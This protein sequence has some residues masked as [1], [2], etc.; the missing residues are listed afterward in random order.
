[1]TDAA[2]AV[3]V[4]MPTF[5][6]APFLGE[7]IGSVLAQ[8][9]A[10][11]ELIVVDDGSTDATDS[12]LASFDD[13]RLRV[14]RRHH[15]GVRAALKAGLQL[16]RGCY[17]ARNDSDDVW[18]PEL[19]TQLLP[20]LEADARVGAVYGRATHID[21]SGRPM[22]GGRG[23][24]LRRPADPLGSLLRTDY[25]CA[26]T[27]VVRREAVD[28]S[29]WADGLST[30]E[31]WETVLRVA[32][33]Y[34]VRFV[35]RVVAQVRLHAGNTIAGPGHAARALHDRLA[36]LESVLSDPAMP[37]ALAASAP[38][39]RREVYIGTALQYVDLRAYGAALRTLAA[40]LAAGGN[41]ARSAARIAWCML[42]WMV[43]S[44]HAFSRTLA[45]RALGYLR[46]S[47]PGTPA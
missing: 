34:D 6:R 10:D 47:A 32:L 36:V 19:L 22:P 8:R 44:R 43:I 29:G 2:P 30:S 20:V 31:D 45:E 17:V 4:L 40:A 27:T 35:D 33:H 41:P 11:L 1:M 9:Y 25:T 24:A 7:A 28:W 13:P 14:L 38:A 46:R 21:G 42:N 16:A 15:A 39:F 37:A 12:L 26:V 3:S 18:R 5:N 23:T